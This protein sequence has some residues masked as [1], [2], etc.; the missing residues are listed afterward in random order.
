MAGPGDRRGKLAA[1]ILA[2][3]KPESKPDDD[4]SED[5]KKTAMSDVFAEFS[6][7]Q[8]AGDEDGAMDALKTFVRMC[9]RGE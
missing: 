5:T 4:D 7:A 9:V 8:R 3:A 2:K 6:A 1:I